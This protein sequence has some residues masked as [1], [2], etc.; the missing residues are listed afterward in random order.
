MSAEKPKRRRHRTRGTK[1]NILP[2][3]KDE[4]FIVYETLYEQ[5]KVQRP[6]RRP[7]KRLASTPE[8]QIEA[9]T[10]TAALVKNLDIGENNVDHEA[11]VSMR[12]LVSPPKLQINALDEATALIKNIRIDENNVA[13]ASG[14]SSKVCYL[15]MRRSLRPKSKFLFYR[16]IHIHNTL[17]SIYILYLLIAVAPKVWKL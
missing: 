8:S 16:D 17:Y 5:K 3:S 6:I 9:K 11:S 12:K 2:E 14:E 10:E 1:E 7:K 4:D 13:S 15:S